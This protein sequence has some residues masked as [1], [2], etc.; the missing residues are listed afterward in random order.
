VRSFA[1]GAHTLDLQAELRLNELTE[2][3]TKLKRQLHTLRDLQVAQLR[4]C[5]C[6]LCL[7]LK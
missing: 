3:N 6:H 7:A 2:E 5:F 4:C 1:S